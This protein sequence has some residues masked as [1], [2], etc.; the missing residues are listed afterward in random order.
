MTPGCTR[1][2]AHHPGELGP[3]SLQSPISA[4]PPEPLE[5]YRNVDWHS[6]DV[7]GKGAAG[8]LPEVFR[9]ADAVVNLARQIQPSHDSRRLFRTNVLSTREIARAALSARVGALVQ[10]SSVGVYSAGP[11]DETAPGGAWPT[12]SG[13]SGQ[14]ANRLLLVL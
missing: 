2:G 7:A 10:A 8:Q 13:V 6:A 4:R 3:K 14:N 9:G 11:K 1:F 5:V 12:D